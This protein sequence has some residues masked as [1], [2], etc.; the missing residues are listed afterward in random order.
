MPV[1]IKILM[2]LIL[3]QMRVFIFLLNKEP[4]LNYNQYNQ[5]L[6]LLCKN[7]H[8]KSETLE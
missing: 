8:R 1:N 3:N 7:T 6:K 5:R 2:W 4:L